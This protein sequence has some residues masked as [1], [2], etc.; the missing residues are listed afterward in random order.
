M[1]P[2]VIRSETVLKKI[3]L[4]AALTT[5]GLLLAGCSQGAPP[6]SK[7]EESKPAATEVTFTDNHGEVTVPVN[8]KRVVALD[9]TVFET[10]SQ[11]N[12]ELVAAPK[13]VMGKS[14]PEYTQNDSVQDVGSHKEPNLEIIVAAE[15]DL[16]IGGYRFAKQYDAIKEQNPNTP[17]IEIAPR[18]GKNFFEEMKRET[19]ILGDIFDKADEAQKI[20]DSLDEKAEEAKKAY[21]G[22]STV[23][24]LIASGGKIMYSAPVTGRAAGGIYPALGLQ[25]ALEQEG[26]ENKHGDEI[27][28][29]AIAQANPDFIIVMDR[30]AAISKPGQNPVPAKELVEGAEALSGVTA[31]AKGQVVYLDP[32]FYLTESIHTYVK[33]LGQ[34]AEAFTSAK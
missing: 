8:P 13:P 5:A 24:S 4:L 19:K 7:K 1:L 11:W 9:N 21:D 29:E 10:L 27:S 14:W 16:I 6:E 32:T 17:V 34:L 30:D 23:L 28:A 15:P 18:D 25:P 22:K 12:V 20:N 3:K 26:E 33:L 2:L 31:V